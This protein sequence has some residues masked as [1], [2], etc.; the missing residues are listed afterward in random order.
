MCRCGAT[1]SGWSAIT[2]IS[3]RVTSVASM[4]ESRTRKSPGSS[5]I[6]RTR[7]DSRIQLVLRRVPVPIDAVVAEVDAGEHDFAVAAVDE[8]ADFV[9]DVLDRPAG[10]LRP[11][12]GDDA[13]AAAQH[14][15]VLHFHVGPVPAAEAAD[16]GGDV[17][18]AEAA[19]QIGQLALVGDDLRHARQRGDFVRAR[20]WRSSP[21]RRS[22]RPDSAAPAGE[23]PAGS[24]SRLRRSRCRC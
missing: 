6:C 8:P 5:A 14:A 18:H 11:H 9:E 2:S 10:E 19:Q 24:W 13:E 7:C 12:V 4:L 3:S 21:S 15:A 23:S 17:G 20:A 22:S 16:A 1:L